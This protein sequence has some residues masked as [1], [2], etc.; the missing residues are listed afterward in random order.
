MKDTLTPPDALICPPEVIFDRDAVQARID[1]VREADP[2]DTAALRQEA[3][4]AMTGAMKA[5]RT[6]IAQALRETPFAAREATRAYTWLTDCAVMTALQVASRHLHPLPNP[7]ESERLTVF[8][9]GGYGRG[10]M[11]P[12]SD[13]DL[14]FL[15]PYKI[16]P[17]AANAS[18]SAP[19]TSPS[20]PR[21]WKS[22][23]FMAM[24]GWRATSTTA[25]ATTSSRAPSANSSR[26]SWKSATPGTR[27]RASATW[28]SP[29]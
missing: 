8:A 14:L 19:T 2:S 17:W 4:T 16:T 7:T 12:F 15:T 5:G 23:C 22:G 18:A 10:E 26:P 27:N 6:A 21:S 29:T 28:S 9:V 1:A 20:A 24:T 3:V 13:V 25:C 11:A